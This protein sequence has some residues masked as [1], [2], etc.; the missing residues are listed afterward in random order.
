MLQQHQIKVWTVHF[1]I[2]L[3]NRKTYG[4][5]VHIKECSPEWLYS[6][7]LFDEPSQREVH[8]RQ[9]NI[10]SFIGLVHNGFIGTWIS[11]QNTSLWGNCQLMVCFFGFI[12]WWQWC[13]EALCY[14]EVNFIG[15]VY[16]VPVHRDVVTLLGWSV[17]SKIRNIHMKIQSAY[18]EWCR[19]LFWKM[20]R[21]INC[22]NNPMCNKVRSDESSWDDQWGVHAGH[23]SI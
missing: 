15:L 18:C 3:A 2:S 22:H 8:I 23:H 11:Q 20:L 10:A 12:G 13:F 7:P 19:L 4:N 16:L 9:Y 5:Q 1:T 6:M 21:Y 14:G 17:S